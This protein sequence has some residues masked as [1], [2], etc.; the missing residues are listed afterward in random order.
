MPFPEPNQVVHQLDRMPKPWAIALGLPLGVGLALAV[1][2][3]P[4]AF[5]AVA[6]ASLLGFAGFIAWSGEPVSV[7]E[8]E[9]PA[10]HTE[11]PKPEPPR[12]PETP[13]VKTPPVADPLWVN[14]VSYTHLTLPTNREV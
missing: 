5:C 6:F 3:M 7:A 8:P 4:L 11:A 10:P 1:L 2:S 12:Q 9:Q 14:T 13:P